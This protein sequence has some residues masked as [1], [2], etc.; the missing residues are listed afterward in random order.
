MQKKEEKNKK[1]A[2]NL[3]GK[4]T[5]TIQVTK[6]KQKAK[7]RSNMINTIAMFAESTENDLERPPGRPPNLLPA[8]KIRFP[9]WGCLSELAASRGKCRWDVR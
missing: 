9:L 8:I 4:K 1:N 6:K 2:P 7:N 3:H 5:T